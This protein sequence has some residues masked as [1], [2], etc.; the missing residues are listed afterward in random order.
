MK[1]SK[2]DFNLREELDDIHQ[3]VVQDIKTD[4]GS[5]DPDVRVAAR[6]EAMQLLKQNGISAAAMPDNAAGEMARMVGKLQNFT[7]IAEKISVRA[8][9]P[10]PA[11][12]R[13]IAQGNTVEVPTPRLIKPE[14][15][16]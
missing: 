3:L 7:A 13:A 12:P 4:L 2:A 15:E 9:L 10:L 6:R 1:T 8:S 14:P 16:H 5:D 11:N